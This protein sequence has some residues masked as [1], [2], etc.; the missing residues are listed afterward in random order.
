MDSSKT[1]TFAELQN[2]FPG[3]IRKETYCKAL[4][5][6]RLTELTLDQ[7]QFLLHQRLNQLDLKLKVGG[8]PADSSCM[9]HALFDQLQGQPSLKDY[10]DS[11]L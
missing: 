1:L 7:G 9:F 11:R 10:A 3:E 5:L 8:T 6:P 4:G 2:Q